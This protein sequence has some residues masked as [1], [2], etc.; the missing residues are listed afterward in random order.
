MSYELTIG[1]KLL[2]Y[3]MTFKIF[4]R[5]KFML[6]RLKTEFVCKEMI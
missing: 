1:N 6:K 4:V 5:I 2:K 3:A